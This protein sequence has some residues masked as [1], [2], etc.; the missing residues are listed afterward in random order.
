MKTRNRKLT[1][2]VALAAV[3]T[4]M[5]APAMAQDAAAA[6]PDGLSNDEI[7]VTAQRRAERLQDVPITIT[8]LTKSQLETADVKTLGDIAKMTPALRFDNQSAFAQPTIRGVGTGV[9]STGVGSNVGIYID[10]F[11]SPNALA[12]DFELLNVQGVQVL[13]GPQGTLFGRNSTGGA[14]LV[15][16]SAPSTETRAVA[17]AS[18]G[19]YDAIKLQAYV[20][21]GLS[22]TVAVDIGGVYRRGNGFLRNIVTGSRR[23]G[24]FEN[25]AMR[26][27]LKIDV[28]DS[29]SILLRYAHNDTDDPTAVAYSALDGLSAGNV[30]PGTIITSRYNRTANSQKNEFQGKTDV[31]QLTID[32][33]LDFAKFTSFTQYRKEKSRSF[34]DFDASSAQ[35]FDLE[36]LTKDKIFTQEFLLVSQGDSRLSWT[37]GLFFFSDDARF[38]GL[39]ASFGGGAPITITESGNDIRSIAGFADATYEITDKLFLTGGIR[40]SRDKVKDP[41]FAVNIPGIAPLPVGLYEDPGTTFKSWTP[42]AVLRYAPNSASSI[43]AS[44]SKGYKAGIINVNGYSFTPIKPEK[45]TSYEVGYKYATRAFQIDLSGYYYDYK[46]LQVANFVGTSAIV[47]NAARSRI[48]GAE[49]Q[50]RYTPS[51]SFEINGGAAYTHA[52]YRSFP[53]SPRYDQCTDPVACGPAFGLFLNSVNDS[54]GGRM[55]RSPDFTA[56]LGVRYA[57]DLAGGELALSSNLYYTSKVFFD[58]SEQYSQ[59]ARELLGLRAQWTDPSDRYTLA[60]YADN[61]TD[62]KYR[63]QVLPGAYAIQQ[64]YAYPFTVGASIRVTY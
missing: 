55:A 13:K 50:F 40:Y 20:T 46:D 5:C 37:T 43:Y 4:A 24:E 39:N 45:L 29:V 28:S 57:V 42:R 32:A 17:E 26:A 53:T 52:R 56:N 62:V 8:S 12:A 9:V 21:T 35:F 64:T 19:S 15:T 11:Y 51:E 61:V 6:Q 18:Y 1:T 48:Y 49:A 14:I 33:D 36:Y 25:W 60:V 3:A 16:T 58:T 54:S 22:D 63:S 59:K 41:F 27:G 31:V 47:T 7:V 38:P 30:V 44:Y 34:I 23:D 2:R 10:G